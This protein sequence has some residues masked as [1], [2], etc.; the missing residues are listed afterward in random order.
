M[1]HS[2]NEMKKM[3]KAILSAVM[4]LL[5]AASPAQMTS[6]WLESAL[7]HKD[8]DYYFETIQ[9]IHPAPYTRYTARQFDSV[10]L[11]LKKICSSPM[12]I[13]QFV[14]TLAMANKLLDEYSGINYLLDNSREIGCAGKIDFR[15]GTLWH[16]G[17]RIESINGVDART[18]FRATDGLVPW[19]YDDDERQ[20]RMKMLFPYVA[21]MQ[22]SVMLPY[23]CRTTDPASGTK[24]S[25]TV[26]FEQYG[27][28][29]DYRIATDKAFDPRHHTVP[30]SQ[31]F[32]D[33]ESIGVFY[34][35]TADPAHAESIRL[36]ADDFFRKAAAKGIRDIFIDVSQNA[37]GSDAVNRHLL[38]HIAGRQYDYTL[39]YEVSDG[40]VA[41]AD[42]MWGRDPAMRPLVARYRAVRSGRDT[43][44][45]SMAAREGYRGRIFV[46]MGPATF[47]AAADFCDQIRRSGAGL[48]VGRPAGQR[49]PYPGNS[50]TLRL[51]GTTLP[52]SCATQ[53]FTTLPSLT[54]R[55]GFL[56]PDITYDMSRRMD[57]QD[58]KNIA[59]K[60][61]AK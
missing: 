49:I 33:Q 50:V 8:I 31:R 43:E 46:I 56:S 53:R 16:G 55:G 38:R 37:G 26:E 44:R 42:T 5:A 54:G 6:S 3:K 4:L 17:M 22:Y 1:V 41:V 28:M 30:A 29:Q 48:L 45:Y 24:G 9:K 57:A 39:K 59:S 10:R 25:A 7:M 35:N 52:F 36:Q 12:I 15:D 23:K 34:Y 14:Y 51:P 58:Y 18:L 32:F 2:N 60:A 19:T 11:E 47:A 13:T 20:R 40:A 61:A 27:S 21:A